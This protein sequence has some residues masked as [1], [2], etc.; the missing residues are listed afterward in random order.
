M[1]PELNE[2]HF[3]RLFLDSGAFSTKSDSYFL[4]RRL[5]L[6]AFKWLFKN[7]YP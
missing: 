3:N 7:G 2:T 1:K 6:E 4:A 5:T